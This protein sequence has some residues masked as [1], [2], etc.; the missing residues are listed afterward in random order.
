MATAPQT[1]IILRYDYTYATGLFKSCQIAG[2]ITNRYNVMNEESEDH[3][4]I[5]LCREPRFPWPELWKRL[6]SFG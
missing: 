1:L 6:R 2:R 5:L 4:T 3:P